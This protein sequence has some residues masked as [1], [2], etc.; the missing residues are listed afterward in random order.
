MVAFG[1]LYMPITKEMLVAR[2]EELQL[3][4][5]QAKAQITA[6]QGALADVEY[7]L[8]KVDEPAADAADKDA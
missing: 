8:S 4:F 5:E 6:L 1:A 3:N 7:W 2:K